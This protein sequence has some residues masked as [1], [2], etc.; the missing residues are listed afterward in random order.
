MSAQRLP[1][2]PRFNDER[3]VPPDW[4]TDALPEVVD[5]S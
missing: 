1:F 3:P 2:P 4:I 5:R